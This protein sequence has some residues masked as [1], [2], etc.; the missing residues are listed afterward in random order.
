[1]NGSGL[2]PG[3]RIKPGQVRGVMDMS[4]H[5]LGLGANLTLVGERTRMLKKI[6]PSF[7]ARSCSWA[8]IYSWSCSWTDEWPWPWSWSWGTGKNRSCSWYGSGH[9]SFRF[10]GFLQIVL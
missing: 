9:S 8:R 6:Y 10:R 5:Y 2:S 1:M 4:F 7:V 3:P